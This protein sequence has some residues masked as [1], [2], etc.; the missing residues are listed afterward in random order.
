MDRLD[1]MSTLLAA[2]ETGSLS[3]ASRRL[4]MPLATVSRKVSDLETHL[5][6]RLLIR[7]SRRL[8]L[9]DAGRNYVAACRRILEDIGEAEQAA[10]GEYSTPRG[11][12]QI[13]API[14]FGRLHVLPVVT[15]FLAAFPEITVRLALADRMVNLL[16]EHADVA[17]RIGAMADSA[18]L[19]TR[20]GAIRRITCA[21][22]AYLAA[23]GTPRHPADL[24]AHSCI[25][26]ETLMSPTSW[27]FAAGRETLAVPVRSR[28][29]VST[30]EAAIDAAIDGIGITRVLSYQVADPVRRGALTILLADHEPPPSPVSLVTNGQGMQPQKLRAFLAFAAPRLRARLDQAALS[31]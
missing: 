20:L 17:V 5:R 25:T 30:A 21:S 13:T 28:L 23:H 1:A 6:T 11:D 26:F 10:A 2:V 15:A 4:G 29:V 3:A 16:E 22:P 7:T 9:T 8:A 14:V 18:L 19:A 31:A 27:T 24:A 12:L